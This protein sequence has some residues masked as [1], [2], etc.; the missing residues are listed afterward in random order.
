MKTTLRTLLFV[1]AI[2]LTACSNGVNPPKQPRADA[3]SPSQIH[4]DSEDLRRDTAVGIPVV[5]RDDSGNLV[6]VTLP[7]RSAINKELHID[8]WVSFFDRNGQ[9]LSKIQGQKTLLANTPDSIE[10]NSMSPRAADFQ[11]DLRY[12]R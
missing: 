10:F 6:H 2:S 12:S 8:Y 1:A 5:T 7:I 9:R 11:V 4:V 3:Y